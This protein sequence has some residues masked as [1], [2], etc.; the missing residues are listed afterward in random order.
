M[1]T[2]ALT[3]RYDNAIPASVAAYVDKMKE[4]SEKP[5][6]L[7]VKLLANF[8]R[9]EELSLKHGTDILR[10][11]VVQLASTY[12]LTNTD[13]LWLHPNLCSGRSMYQGG[14]AKTIEF[15]INAFNAS[16]AAY[17]THSI[18]DI[19]TLQSE[20]VTIV[21]NGMGESA[22]TLL[23][24]WILSGETAKG[25]YNELS[26]SKLNITSQKK[27]DA[28]AEKCGATTRLMN[29]DYNMLY[30]DGASYYYYNH[31]IKPDKQALI[32]VS[33][34]VGC[35]VVQTSET[36]IESD[37]LTTSDFID[38]NSLESTQRHRAYVDCRWKGKNI[39]NTY[40]MRKP[41][42][43]FKEFL[44]E[45]QA[46]M[47][48]MT[49]GYFSANAVHDK[50]PLKTI[51]ALTPKKEIIPD[52]AVCHSQTREGVISMQ[53][54]QETIGKLMKNNWSKLIS[55]KYVKGDMLLLPRSM[56]EDLVAE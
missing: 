38:V 16:V 47:Y 21:D 3:K 35:A 4:L 31:A 23:T 44:G 41:F 56:I 10:G 49:S 46:K 20:N 25:A 45:R 8:G 40:T 19:G 27:R 30:S 28:L 51:L 32:N 39:I 12:T 50:L 18:D 17:T 29:S 7:K 26:Q 2:S 55:K 5:G 9:D 36:E 34:M 42:E 37:L 15:D 33:P 6:V 1:D 48:R 52:Q 53:A 11:L 13:R 14:K 22:D 24:S 54:T 43:G